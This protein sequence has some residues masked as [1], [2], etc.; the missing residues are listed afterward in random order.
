MELAQGKSLLSSQ[1]VRVTRVR[2]R[3][4]SDLHHICTN[5]RRQRLGGFVLC[6]LHQIVNCDAIQ[7]LLLHQIYAA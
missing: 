3:V 2:V 5:G 6:S 7:T 1:L 4:A